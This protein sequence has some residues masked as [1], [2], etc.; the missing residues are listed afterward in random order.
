MKH[1]MD[2]ISILIFFFSKDGDYKYEIPE[3]HR[4]VDDSKTMDI[5][6]CE[7]KSTGIQETTLCE[8]CNRKQELKLLELREVENSQNTYSSEEIL[9]FKESLEEK[10]PLCHDCEGTV[11]A[12]LKKQ[13]MWLLQYKMLLFKNK[14]IQ[15][16]FEVSGFFSVHDVQDNF[17]HHNFNIHF[18]QN[19]GK[20]ARTLRILLSLLALVTVY[21][22]E[23]PYLPVCGILLQCITFLVTRAGLRHTGFFP[24]VG[25]I[26]LTM[27][28]EFKISSFLEA[29]EIHPNIQWTTF[30]DNTYKY[31]VSINNNTLQ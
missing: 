22:S 8:E 6:Y 25:W 24:L 19:R 14:P 11:A 26:L 23:I 5:T 30:P 20:I 10:Y 29:F 28:Q 12:V 4:S 9:Q 3:Q 17:I 2:S 18:L 1:Y 21:Y 15:Q 16:I 13:S 31:F 7:R 27:V